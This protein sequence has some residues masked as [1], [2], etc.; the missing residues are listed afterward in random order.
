MRCIPFFFAILL[1][2]FP[3]APALA[4]TPKTHEDAQ[5]LRKRLEEERLKVKS[6]E[7]KKQTLE[8]T[9]NSEKQSLKRY[10]RI[11]KDYQYNL[12]EAQKVIDAADSEMQN[13]TERTQSWESFYRKCVRAATA[14]SILFMAESFSSSLQRKANQEAAEKIA[15]DIFRNIQT[16]Q[17]RLQ[18]LLAAIQ[19]KR[20]FQERI[21]NRYMP[22]D[23]STKEN[24]EQLIGEKEEEA[25]ITNNDYQ[26]R[27]RSIEEL[28]RQLKAWEDRIAEI[29]RQ[30]MLEEKKKREEQKRLLAERKKQEQQRLLA[31]QQAK[32]NPQNPADAK[33]A[34]PKEDAPPPSSSPIVSDGRSF[35]QLQG[36]LP[37]PARGTV[38]RP[39]GEYVYPQSN[40]KMKSPGI[41]VRIKAGTS[42]QAVAAGEVLYAGDIPGFGQT[43]IIA[44]DED[45]LTVYGRVAE[46][47]SVHQSIRA[48][49]VIGKAIGMENQTD[50]HFEIRQGKTA[51]NPLLW[52]SR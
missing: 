4:Q 7:Q 29:N 8:R 51:L 48:G 43:V 1:G 35:P 12:K 49:Q 39:F 17:P 23:Q 47:V 11:L 37:W 31:Q 30:R 15:R 22:V 34:A 44:H 45:Y 18:E 5:A 52:L 14:R 2:F 36:N 32:K 41:D 20:E 42:I 38:I 13:I 27:L 46:T 21:L 9:I 25:V 3:I 16:Q 26:D 24:K 10:D 40:I 33:T 19:D 28:Q 50:Y 6:L